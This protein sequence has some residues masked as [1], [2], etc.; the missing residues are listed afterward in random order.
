MRKAIRKP[1]V[2]AALGVSNS[3]LYELILKGIV[4]AGAK[5]DHG[6]TVI[7]WEDEIEAIQKRAVQAA[8]GMPST[9]KGSRTLKS[10]ARPTQLPKTA[11]SQ[12][13]GNQ[14]TGPPDFGDTKTESR[15][16]LANT[17]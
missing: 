7:W 8:A 9:L 14:H 6:R 11:Q 13:P 15:S 16:E 12:R 1:A 5:I 3:T 4:P 2:L 17:P 10:S